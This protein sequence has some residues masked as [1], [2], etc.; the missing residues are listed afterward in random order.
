MSDEPKI[1]SSKLLVS[2]GL[3]SYPLY[4]WHWPALA[5]LKITE[6]EP[7]I[8]LKIAAI[9][10]AC[11][12]SV[13]T[14]LYVEKPIRRMQGKNK[15]AFTLLILMSF[16]ALIGIYTHHR[17]G[18]DF[19][20]V[21]YAVYK[22]KIK[23]TVLAYLGL[24][25]ETINIP[26]SGYLNQAKFEKI[27]PEYDGKLLKLI[28]TL[29]SSS[30]MNA[31]KNDFDSVNQDGYK[32]GEAKCKNGI[33]GQTIVIVGDSHAENFYTAIASTHK[34]YNVVRFT[35]AGCT[36]IASRYR[37]ADNRCKKLLGRALSYVQTN[38]VELLILAARW[39]ENYA[40]VVGDIESY[41]PYVKNV[42]LAG[43][44]VVFFHEVSQILLRYDGAM[45][46]NQYVNSQMDFERF[47]L[48]QQ[49]HQFAQLNNIH[50]IDRIAP[51]C[52]DGLCRLTLT[53]KELLIFDN[54]H[55]SNAG[56]KYVGEKL[57]KNRVIAN[58]VS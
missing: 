45:E 11:I 26:K 48:N 5:F 42:A 24:Q 38:K 3:I 53:G 43:P 34:N 49:M 8:T 7:G 35:D 21:N 13:V 57:L 25:G 33:A 27:D 52:G 2:I 51:L 47:E 56:A 23:Q 39:P 32:C 17:E 37:D 36:P 19:R 44:S 9:A 14:Y 15:M 30:G 50:Y 29:K 20:E 16:T 40:D 28:G 46:V 10:V 41:K 31:I 6:L 58:L 1:L 55:L 54:G 22:N 12:L 18:M 4:I